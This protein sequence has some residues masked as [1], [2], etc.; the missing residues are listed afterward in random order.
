MLDLKQVGDRWE[1]TVTHRDVSV[2]ITR[3]EKKNALTEGM[4]IWRVL[5]ELDRMPNPY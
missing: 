2:T 5:E 3:N 1:I 4:A